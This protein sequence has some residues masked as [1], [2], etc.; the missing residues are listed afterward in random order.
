M[1]IRKLPDLIKHGD[2]S[3][4]LGQRQSPK[5]LPCPLGGRGDT[6]LHRA[7]REWMGHVD[8]GRIGG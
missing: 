4:R 1:T 8:G 6:D 5:P 7:W 2:K 3:L